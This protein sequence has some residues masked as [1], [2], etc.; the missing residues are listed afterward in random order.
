MLT[1]FLTCD[2]HNSN[3]GQHNGKRLT[4]NLVVVGRSHDVVRVLWS[5]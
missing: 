5:T 3:N 2:A 4:T 1:N